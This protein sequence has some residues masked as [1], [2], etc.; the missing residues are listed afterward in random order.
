[1]R[2]YERTA[3]RRHR[4]ETFSQDKRLDEFFSAGQDKRLD[5]DWPPA[6]RSRQS[7]TR[8]TGAS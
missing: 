7:T 5:M 2:N 1:V 4:M 3:F 8:T 6:R